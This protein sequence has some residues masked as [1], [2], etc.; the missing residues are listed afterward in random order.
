M[1]QDVSHYLWTQWLWRVCLSPALPGHTAV[2]MGEGCCGLRAGC[3]LPVWLWWEGLR[4]LPTPQRHGVHR[5]MPCKSCP[6]HGSSPW[7]S[8]RIASSKASVHSGKRASFPQKSRS[9]RVGRFTGQTH[10][11]KTQTEGLGLCRCMCWD[12]I[13]L[14][15]SGLPATKVLMFLRSRKTVPRHNDFFYLFSHREDICN[16]SWHLF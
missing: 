3:C 2:T 15:L 13:R 4:S 9:E 8:R 14:S 1:K 12:T 6:R 10:T 7:P 11:H 5:K 16:F